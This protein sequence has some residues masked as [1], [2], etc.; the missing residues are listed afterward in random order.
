MPKCPECKAEIESLRHYEKVERCFDFGLDSEE[1]P[2]Y[3]NSEIIDVEGVDFEWLCPECSELITEN[4]EEAI[5][6][7]K[8]EET[9]KTKTQ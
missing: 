5:N 9:N 6:F 7:L 8:N 4:E 1:K 3:S 2:D